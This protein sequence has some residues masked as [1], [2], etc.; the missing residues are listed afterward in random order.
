MQTRVVF[1]AGWLM[2]GLMMSWLPIIGHAQTLQVLDATDREPIAGVS[3]WAPTQAVHEVSNSDGALS[4]ARF[5]GAKEIQIYALGYSPMNLSYEELIETLPQLFLTR[6]AIQLGD[7]VVSATRWRQ[8]YSS[9]AQAITVIDPEQL[10]RQQPQTMADALGLSAKVFIQKSQQGG[11]SPMIRGFA[12]N[13]LLYTVDGIRM[14]SAI[15]RAGNI[16]NVINLDPFTMERTEV[17]FGPNSVMYGSDAIGGVMS[18]ETITPSFAIDTTRSWSQPRISGRAVVRATSANNEQ[19]GHFDMG[20]GW[21]KLAWVGSISRWDFDHLKQGSNGPDDYLKPSYVQEWQGSF[22]SIMPGEV[23]D[24]VRV[25]SEPLLQIPSGYSQWNS[26][27]KVRWKPTQDLELNYGFHFSETSEYGRYDRHLRTRDEQP[28]YARWDYGPQTWSMHVLSLNHRGADRFGLYDELMVKTALQ[29]FKESRIS[30]NFGVLAEK[31]QREQVIAQS[32]QFDAIKWLSETHIVSYGVEWVQND[33]SST[34]F[35]QMLGSG[36]S[37]SILPRYPDAIWNSTALFL[38]SDWSLKEDLQLQMGLRYNSFSIDANFANSDVLQL[39]VQDRARLDDQALVGSLGL[40]ARPSEQWIIKWTLGTAFRSPNVDDMG[41]I[42]DS[43]PGAVTVPNPNL[44]AEYAWNT[45]VGIAHTVTQDVKIEFNAFWTQLNNAMVRRDYLFNGASTMIYDGI[46]SRIQAIQ[47]AAYARVYGF[48]V[49]L[50][51]GIRRYWTF[52]T[53]IN[54]QKG[55]EELDDG[56]ISQARHAVPAFGETGIYYEKKG[57]SW[58][59]LHRFQTEKKY[60]DMPLSERA[61]AELY[62]KDEQG[63]PYAPAWQVIHLNGSWEITQGAQLLLRFENLTD[64][65][66]R[67]YSSGISA[68][69]RSIQLGL[70]IRF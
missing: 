49:G 32:I 24:E 19:T 43:E 22:A 50:D 8:N 15:F 53:R 28:R 2:C 55:I 27:Q 9:V 64:Q 29:N 3:F 5:R 41:K 68:S 33:V 61:K 21:Q 34:A 23:P 40:I 62:A 59:L 16:Q 58:A 10:V 26:M 13:R 37:Q 1:I 14:N 42:F 18:F 20:L 39:W 54:V 47:N 70:N 51:A 56:S 46:E 60:Q 52:S 4:V 38:H 31:H 66:Y 11:G 65:R 7:L 36:Q 30:R 44:K 35:E 12:T 48:Y 69:G 63:L 67:P 6:A 45:D 57:W 17:L 25:Q